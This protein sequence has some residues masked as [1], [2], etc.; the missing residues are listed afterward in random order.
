[1]WICNKDNTAIINVD[2]GCVINYSLNE[3]KYGHDWNLYFNLSLILPIGKREIIEGYSIDDEIK[4]EEKEKLVIEYTNKIKN[5]F[6][7]LKNKLI[8]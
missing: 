3:M 4:G 2:S 6:E 8:K 5:S 1:M 7:E